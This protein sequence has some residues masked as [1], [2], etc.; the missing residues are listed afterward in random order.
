MND[1]RLVEALR[2]LAVQDSAREAPAWVEARL[3]EALQRRR[4]RRAAWRAGIAAVVVIAAFLAV[5]GRRHPRPKVPPAQPGTAVAVRIPE[6]VTPALPRRAL[7]EEVRAAPPEEVDTP[8]FPLLDAPP[9]F[10]RGELVRVTL[11]ASAMRVVGLPVG[12]ERLEEPVLADVLIG[13]EGMARA[14]RFVSFEP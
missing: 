4:R 5:A 14:I 3:V 13:E 12:E 10:E 7:P 6:P 9:P 1:E 8:F 11:P 2:A